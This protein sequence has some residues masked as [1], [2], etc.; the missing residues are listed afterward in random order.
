MY[1]GW[2]YDGW[3]PPGQKCGQKTRQL[4]SRVPPAARGPRRP[5]APRDHTCCPR[6]ACVRPTAPASRDLRKVRSPVPT[7][8]LLAPPQRIA[9]CP[10][11]RLCS[12]LACASTRARLRGP[13]PFSKTQRLFPAPAQISPGRKAALPAL[14]SVL[15]ASCPPRG[16]PWTRCSCRRDPCAPAVRAITAALLARLLHPDRALLQRCLYGV[17]LLLPAGLAAAGRSWAGGAP[18]GRPLSPALPHPLLSSLHER[19]PL[20]CGGGGLLL[21]ARLQPAALRGGCAAGRP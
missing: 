6:L 13:G 10:R 9:H 20:H 14:L 2:M 11:S 15:T 4:P 12:L 16:A 8:A 19:A 3:P 21:G 5:S 7:H 17:A 18:A 1:A